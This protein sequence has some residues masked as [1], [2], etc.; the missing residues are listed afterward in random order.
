MLQ[1][2][3]FDFY[4]I[5]KSKSMFFVLIA[6]LIIVTIDIA[7][8]YLEHEFLAYSVLS[9]MLF[10]DKLSLPVTLFAV[11]FCTKDYS[12]TYIKNVYTNV[13]KLKYTLSKIVCLFVFVVVIAIYSFIVDTILSYTIG[14]GE[15][16]IEER[17][18]KPVING[19]EY[20]VVGDS[21]DFTVD[22]FF[23]RY[24]LHIVQLTAY[25]MLINLVATLVNNTLTAII[26]IGWYFISSTV[27]GAINSIINIIFELYEPNAVNLGPYLIVQNVQGIPWESDATILIIRSLIYLVVA[28]LLSW[29]ALSKKEF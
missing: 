4:K 6:T 1:E 3:K 19:V 12:S 22:N 16:Y 14:I 25:G 20:L 27:W 7:Q 24:F 13:N 21:K 11:F 23:F 17:Y 5:F 9:H 10:A 28:T 2:I 29:L 26:T 18:I 8:D 15:I